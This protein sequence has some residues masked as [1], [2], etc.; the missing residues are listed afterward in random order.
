[1]LTNINEMETDVIIV[2]GG[3]AGTRAALAAAEEGARVTIIDK[4]RAGLD[5]AT[6]FTIKAEGAWGIQ[7][8]LN[9]FSD[10]TYEDHFSEVIE[11][12]EGVCD[13]ELVKILVEE[14]PVR[15]EE[16]IDWGLSFDRDEKGEL[17]REVGCFSSKARALHASAPVTIANFLI[18]KVQEHSRIQIMN[19]MIVVDLITYN[20]YCIG[21]LAKDVNNGDL[22]YIRSRSVILTNGGIGNLFKYNVNPSELCGDGLAMAFRAGAKLINMEFLQIGIGFLSP[23]T[24][25]HV[26]RHIWLLKPEILDNQGRNLVEHYLPSNINSDKIYKERAGHFPFTCSDESFYIDL[27]INEANKSFGESTGAKLYINSHQIDN[28]L[29]QFPSFNKIQQLLKSK[30]L[31]WASK[32][33]RIG[34][35]F[36][37]INGG[38]KIKKDG[39]VDGVNGVFAAGEVADGVHGANRLGGNMLLATQVFGYRSGKAAASFSDYN[40]NHK[41][42]KEGIEDWKKRHVE[43]KGLS[44]KRINEITSLLKEETSKELLVGR[45]ENGLKKIKRDILQWEIE[46]DQAG[47]PEED[48]LWLKTLELQNM[49]LVAKLI[50]TAARERKESRGSHYR[51]DYPEKDVN[52]NCSLILSQAEAN[53]RKGR[54]TEIDITRSR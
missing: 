14:G 15:V 16:L 40:Y 18:K 41:V 9:E 10:D 23:F 33:L 54:D 25:V 7:A 48:E 32:D 38:I 31:T 19:K 36:H 45:T 8:S 42:Y 5:G 51:I 28:K 46:L 30:G 29:E 1:M 47:W 53:K 3:A 26:P 49:L 24:R 4:A 13:P 6:N 21:V 22:Y 43:G 12:G 2:G 34:L 44:L 35:Y 17:I 52:Y 39:A 11:A 37:A 50:T 27:I 20:N